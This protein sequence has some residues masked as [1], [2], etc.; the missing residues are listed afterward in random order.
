MK[1]SKDE[2]NVGLIVASAS[3]GLLGILAVAA[4]IVY[5][6]SQGDSEEEEE[7]EGEKTSQQ[8]ICTS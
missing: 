3:A 8:L 1:D 2:E 4:V 7:E 6:K 5:C